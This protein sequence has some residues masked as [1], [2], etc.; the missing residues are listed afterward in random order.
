LTGLA[1]Q[2]KRTVIVGDVRSDMRYL[3]AFGSTISEIIIPVLDKN[4]GTVVGTI[5]VESELV[6]AFSDKDQKTLEE[7]ANAA[8]GLWSIA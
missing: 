1:I 2:E 5:D 7:C 6:N 4:T 8:R 3:T